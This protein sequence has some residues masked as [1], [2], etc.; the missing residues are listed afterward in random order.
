MAIELDE[1]FS[2]VTTI[3]V[4][5]KSIIHAD[6]VFKI[7]VGFFAVI[8]IAL[9]AWLGVQLYM[10]AKL[11]FQDNG[12]WNFIKGTT[13][14]PVSGVFGALPF[15]YGTLLTAFLALLIAT[16]LGIGTA[17]FLA[18]L[19]P[20]WLKG[21]LQPLVELL[22]GIPSVIYGLWGIFV[23]SP[24]MASTIE[25]FLANKF[26]FLPIFKGYPLGVGFLTASIILSIM[27]VPFIISV[28]TEV[29]S[30]V[31][32]SLKEG[33]YALGAT[34]WETVKRIAF[35]FAKS[36]ILGSIILALARALGETMAVT[37]VIGNT[38]Q[39]SKSLFDPGYTMAAVIANEFTEATY[40]AY[41]SAL[42]AIAFILLLI[43]L[44]VNG[45]ARWLI[46]QTTR[47]E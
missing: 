23:L 18:E 26:G 7:F 8:V 32:L 38:P 31:P 28:S 15:I 47:I 21:F 10:S 44:V 17:I 20:K 13:W 30:A 33:M 5:K 46:W 34:R 40:A 19:S 12:F 25:P 43:T 24:F 36:G 11:A 29:L 35:P 27:I 37:M 4:R 42:I 2:P 16:P 45:I 9:L 22:A 14:D 6:T 1:L 3:K 39:I 41:S